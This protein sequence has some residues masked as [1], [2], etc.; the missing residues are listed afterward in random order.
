[1]KSEA[2]KAV[3]PAFT[4]TIMCESSE[5]EAIKITIPGKLNRPPNTYFIRPK[6]RPICFSDDL[7]T[8]S[9]NRLPVVLNDD[10]SPWVEANLYLLCRMESDINQNMITYHGISDDLSAY[11][12]YLED[13]ELDFKLFSFT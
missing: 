9:Y 5:P 10:G 13:E 4:L 7:D 6:K 11:R 1:M 12:R 8:Y 3:I 2:R